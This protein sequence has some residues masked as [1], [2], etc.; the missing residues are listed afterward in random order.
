MSL[1]ERPPLSV[2]ERPADL[3][4]AFQESVQRHAKRTALVLSEEHISY[5]SLDMLARRWAEALLF[6]GTRKPQRVGILA[7]RNRVSY[8]GPLAALYAGATF[9]PLNPRFPRARTAAMVEAAELDAL[10]CDGNSASVAG[11]LDV[12]LVIVPEA[13]DGRVVRGAARRGA[14]VVGAAELGAFTAV[15]EALPLQPDD[16]V[17]LMFTSGSTGRPKGVPITH[18]NVLYFLRTAQARY[19]IGPTDRLSQTFDQSFD[20]SIFD[21]FM[22]WLHGAELHA[23][24]A[25][26][27]VAPGRFIRSH[28]LT[29]WFSVPS[30]ISMMTRKKGVL[31]PGAFPSLR[32]SLF[33]GETLTPDLA[34]LW[35]AAAPSSFV[36]NLYGPTEVTLS[37][38]W[39]RYQP[40]VDDR[41][42]S[43]PIGEPF[44]AHEVSLLDAAGA[45]CPSTSSEGELAIA[46]PQ[47]GPGYWRA[48]ELTEERFVRFEAAG[49]IFYRT[50]DLVRR[51]DDHTYLYLGRIDHQVKVQGFRV[52]LA[53]VERVARRAASVVEAV[54][55]PDVPVDGVLQGLV[56]FIPGPERD[57]GPILDQL[58]AELPAYMVPKRVIFLAELPLNANGKVDRAA[59]AQ[60]LEG[61]P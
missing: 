53:E 9:V 12:P 44:P 33:C 36:D 2:P 50:G 42:P 35:S 5:G 17:Y 19:H 55:M 49:P 47:V 22:S 27:L 59:L 7:S 52:E 15:R 58:K 60:Q 48:P 29:V 25:I 26:D 3:L 43:V 14:V 20:L 23:M 45:I 28:E 39:H 38:L 32:A 21:L 30:M 8:V 40:S 10:I 46:G 41:H 16:M 1:Q 11:T 31:T 57:F 51:L 18:R 13:M 56:V 61:G 4:T 6:G 34:K 24:Q 37:C 54:V